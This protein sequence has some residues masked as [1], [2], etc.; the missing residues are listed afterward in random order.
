[1][2]TGVD[3]KRND[4]DPR[5]TA[6]NVPITA[7]PTIAA[8]HFFFERNSRKTYSSPLEMPATL[9]CVSFCD[10]CVNRRQVEINARVVGRRGWPRASPARLLP[11]QR[12]GLA[13]AGPTR[14]LAPTVTAL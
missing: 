5:A 4:G 13:D 10:V 9:D 8:P 7:T 3:V 2:T 6:A 11:S 14:P 12:F 1:V